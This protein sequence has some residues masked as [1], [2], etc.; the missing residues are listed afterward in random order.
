MF[1]PQLEDTLWRNQS[2]D[3][4]L[5]ADIT[6]VETISLDIV[7]KNSVDVMV[8]AKQQPYVINRDAGLVTDDNFIFLLLFNS[9]KFSIFFFN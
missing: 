6:V 8:I 7:S 3:A 5:I 4:A 2:V 1:N 9:N